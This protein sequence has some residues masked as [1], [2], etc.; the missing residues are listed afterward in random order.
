MPVTGV[1]GFWGLALRALRV[2]GLQ[3]AAECFG[4]SSVLVHC[5][6]FVALSGVG[7]EDGL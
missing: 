5:E 7:P 4:A 6:A 2:L 1:L 3:F